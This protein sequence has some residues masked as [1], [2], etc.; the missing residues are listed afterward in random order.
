LIKGKKVVLVDDV[1]TSGKTLKTV[2]EIAVTS[3]AKVVLKL[4]VFKQGNHTATNENEI[5]FMHNLP[6]FTTTSKT[7]V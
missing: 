5:V 7:P 4:A 1:V 2:E 3:G 6:V